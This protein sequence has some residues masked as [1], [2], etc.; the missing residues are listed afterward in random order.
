MKVRVFAYCD[1]CS[2][3]L[4]VILQLIVLRKELIMYCYVNKLY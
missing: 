4:W 1:E 3:N 2:V